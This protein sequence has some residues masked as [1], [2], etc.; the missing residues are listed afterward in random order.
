MLPRTDTI[1]SSLSC[2]PRP[3]P[4]TES[5]SPLAYGDELEAI[6]AGACLAVFG[7][8]LKMEDV[9]M[10]GTYAGIR[11]LCGIRC[12]QL[13]VDWVYNPM[14]PVPGRVYPPRSVSL[15]ACVRMKDAGTA[16]L[17]LAG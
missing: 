3:A 6:P 14:P 10:R 16:L 11:R 9:L 1:G 17:T 7:V 8:T 13:E 2:R 4:G 15:C 5:F 12:G